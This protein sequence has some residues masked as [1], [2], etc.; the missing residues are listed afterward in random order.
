MLGG[1]AAFCAGVAGAAGAPVKA[2]TLSAA[3]PHLDP[4]SAAPCGHAKVIASDASTV[5]ETSPGKIRGFKRDG[6]YIF[7]GVPFGASTSGARRF[8]PPAQPEP[9]TGIR[10]ALAYGRVCPQQD[11]AHFNMDGKNLASADEDSFLLHRGSAVTYL[12]KTACA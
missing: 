5:V 9:W 3:E 12:A 2:V 8:M 10:N 11:S 6:V 1:I 4:Q 7:K